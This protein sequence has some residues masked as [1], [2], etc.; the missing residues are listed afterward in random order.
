MES[1][2]LNSMITTFLTFTL[3]CN[4]FTGF[5]QRLMKVSS[6]TEQ[7]RTE[8]LQEVVQVAPKCPLPIPIVKNGNL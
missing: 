6:L 4:Q 2:W 1:R 5:V 8:I 7:Q 3:T